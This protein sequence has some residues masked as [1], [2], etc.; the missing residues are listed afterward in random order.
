M[1]GIA[2]FFNGGLGKIINPISAYISAI[3]L[4][5]TSIFCFFLI[6]NDNFRKC[7][8]HSERGKSYD[9]WPFIFVGVLTLI[10]GVITCVTI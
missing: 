10:L 7:M 3:A 5:G 6:K 4:I 2:I 8:L 1:F 9:N